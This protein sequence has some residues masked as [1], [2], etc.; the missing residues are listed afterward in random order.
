[1]CHGRREKNRGYNTKSFI[2]QTDRQ[3]KGEKQMGIE[4]LC[5]KKGCGG[6][7]PLAYRF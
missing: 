1:M 7:A 6:T 4:V 2:Q 5:R 3:R